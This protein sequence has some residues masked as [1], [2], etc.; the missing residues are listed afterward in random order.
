MRF[1]H[2][3]KLNVWFAEQMAALKTEGMSDEELK[4]PAATDLALR[5]VFEEH[6]DELHSDEEFI[7]EAFAVV[8]E[9]AF[10]VDLR[11]LATQAREEGNLEIGPYL[12]LIADHR[13]K[14]FRQ[15]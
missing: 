4:D 6:F 7:E 12:E 1:D 8:S 9:K 3:Q 14:T 13:E 5:K 2:L 10:P 11:E 15:L